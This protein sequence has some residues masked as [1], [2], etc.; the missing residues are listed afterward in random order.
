MNKQLIT[1][2][3][4]EQVKELYDWIEPKQKD[5]L[6]QY[7]TERKLKELLLNSGLQLKDLKHIISNKTCSHPFKSPSTVYEMHLPTEIRYIDEITKQS[8]VKLVYNYTVPVYNTQVQLMVLRYL[9]FYLSLYCYDTTSQDS[10]YVYFD[11]LA[12][13]VGMEEIF[14]KDF[15]KIET[16]MKASIKN[17]VEYQ[18]TQHWRERNGMEKITE[19]GQ[20]ERVKKSVEW[21]LLKQWCNG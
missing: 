12:V 7:V 1:A 20:W 11:G 6:L 3:Q 15:E 17:S 16:N 5:F 8:K 10:L 9:G 18:P 4:S 13:N 14:S 2:I 21:K 19:N